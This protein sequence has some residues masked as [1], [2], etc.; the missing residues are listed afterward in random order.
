[1]M[2]KRAAGERLVPGDESCRSCLAG[3]ED[4]PALPALPGG[5][6]SAGRRQA[7][8]ASPAISIRCRPDALTGRQ[9]TDNNQMHRGPARPTAF[10]GR[11][12]LA[13][14]NITHST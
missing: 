10:T 6:Q 9:N 4:L 13:W 1:M 5:R 3:D 8:V 14:S 2:T 12:A 7:G 11:R